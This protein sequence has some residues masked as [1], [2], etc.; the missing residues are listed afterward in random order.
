MFLGEIIPVP[1]IRKE[2]LVVWGKHVV[3]R[4]V[5]HKGVWVIYL[6]S[7]SN[8]DYGSMNRV[9]PAINGI[10]SVKFPYVLILLRRI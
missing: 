6:C 2:H 1:D 3:D 7:T 8:S 9:P 10:T 5:G 4:I